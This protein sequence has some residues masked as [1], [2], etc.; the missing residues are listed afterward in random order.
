MHQV[1][2]FIVSMI[3]T[4]KSP[5]DTDIKST[6]LHIS[7]LRGICNQ[8][9]VGRYTIS[10]QCTLF[11]QVVHIPNTF[12]VLQG[13]CILKREKRATASPIYL[14]SRDYTQTVQTQPT[15]LLL[16]PLPMLQRQ[17]QLLPRNP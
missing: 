14:K 2:N 8:F 17:L 5:N 7:L 9:M 3:T 6:K 13:I 4:T 11:T 10:A 16:H 1:L 12:K 15:P